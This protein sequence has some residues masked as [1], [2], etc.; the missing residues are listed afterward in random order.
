[1]AGAG[2]NPIPSSIAATN[3]PRQTGGVGQW[4]GWPWAPTMPTKRKQRPGTGWK[5]AA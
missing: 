5:A 2:L 3:R 1:M 4:A